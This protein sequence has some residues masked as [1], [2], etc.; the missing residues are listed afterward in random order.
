[1]L[2]DVS[3]RDDAARVQELKRRLGNSF[4]LVQAVIQRRQRRATEPAVRRELGMI[5]Q[6]V[7]SIGHVQR[8][9]ED[10][11]GFDFADHQLVVAQ[12]WRPLLR[13]RRVELNINLMSVEVPE[14]T[15][16]ALA[17]IAHELIAN[18]LEHA[19]TGDRPGRIELS[20]LIDEKGFVELSVADNGC[21]M[22][23]SVAPVRGGLRLVRGLARRVGGS[24]SLHDGRGVVA[25]V[26]FP[27]PANED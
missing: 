4:Q 24:F 9:V 1:M 18:S 10:S 21:G 17:L 5:L 16:S 6:A 27:L 8:S 7:T 22:S 2:V 13:E 26:W 19:F 25:S 20:L 15:G 12:Q 11:A 14:A 23:K 3:P